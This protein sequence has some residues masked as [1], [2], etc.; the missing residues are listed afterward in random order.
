MSRNIIIKNLIKKH[1][2]KLRFA[3]VGGFNTAIDFVILFSLVAL[4]LPTIASN[5][6]ST[7]VA[8]IFSF[9]ANK[10]F[11]FK[12]NNKVNKTQFPIF[13]II[14]LFGLWIIQPIIIE[15]TKNIA[16]IMLKNNDIIILF[17]GKALA[18]CVT[19]VWNYL[20]YRKFVF[21]K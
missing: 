10:K 4:G 11:T 21:K 13:L 5:I 6:L 12:N 20:L 9:F 14:T 18:T 3:I 16:G 19:L 2:D 1:E 17:I 7:S 8:L 15:L